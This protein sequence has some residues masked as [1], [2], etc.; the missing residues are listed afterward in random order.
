MFN[1]ARLLL[2]PQQRS[3]GGVKNNG[4]SSEYLKGVR[5]RGY[6]AFT[7]LAFVRLAHIYSK[8]HSCEWPARVVQQFS[9]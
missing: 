5:R 7:R 6:T 8:T 4:V 1:A 2:M 3:S 9:W